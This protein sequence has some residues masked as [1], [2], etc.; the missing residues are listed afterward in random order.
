DYRWLGSRWAREGI[1]L[2][3]QSFFTRQEKRGP[4]TPNG[5]RVYAIGDVHGRADLLARLLATIDAD[6]AARP[7]SQVIEVLLGDYID[8]GPQSRD[9]LDLLVARSERHQL[10]CLKGNHETYIAEFLRNPATLTQWRH[11][12]ALATL[13]SYGLA[14]SIKPDEQE[15]QELAAALYRALPSSHRR[16]LAELKTSLV[17]GDYFFVHAGIRPGIPL[18]EQQEQDLL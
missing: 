4:R 10:I 16:F 8:R 5:L 3:W 14:P 2:V 18:A 1:Q 9:V 11:Y 6:V 15:Q 13:V 12:G 17:C 7:A